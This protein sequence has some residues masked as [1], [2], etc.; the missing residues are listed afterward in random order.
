MLVDGTENDCPFFWHFSNGLT[1]SKFFVQVSLSQSVHR[2]RE[3][4][5]STPI[6]GSGIFVYCFRKQ[7]SI[8]KTT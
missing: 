5:R 4:E 2:E 6:P 3:R 1:K 8:R 7:I